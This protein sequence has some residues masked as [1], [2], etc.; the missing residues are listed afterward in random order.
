MEDGRKKVLLCLLIIVL[1]AV[2]IGLI[3]YLSTPKE[4]A[5]E[6]FLIKDMHMDPLMRQEHIC[7]GAQFEAGQEVRDVL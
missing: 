5:G 7:T 6:G 2:V 4:Q 1:A 3:Y